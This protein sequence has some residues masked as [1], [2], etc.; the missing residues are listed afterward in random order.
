MHKGK[1]QCSILGL[2][3]CL[4]MVTALK[5]SQRRIA[6]KNAYLIILNK[7]QEF[8]FVISL[9]L[10]HVIKTGVNVLVKII[11]LTPLLILGIQMK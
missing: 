11:T 6:F 7:L 2:G 10:K 1:Y 5:Y 8:G 4:V 3:E 9:S